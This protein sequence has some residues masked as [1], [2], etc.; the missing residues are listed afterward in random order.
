MNCSIC[1]QTSKT[2]EKC[3]EE[4][5]K[6]TPEFINCINHVL[7]AYGTT[8]FINCEIM[9]EIDFM[10]ENLSGCWF[11]DWLNHKLY[12][13]IMKNCILL[14]ETVPSYKDFEDIDD[15]D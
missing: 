5:K 12:S 14:N 8:L 1:N 4:E 13:E 3:P 2:Q 11:M 6:E 7:K 10:Y 15:D 9:K